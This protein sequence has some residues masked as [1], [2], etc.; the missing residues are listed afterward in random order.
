MF[1]FGFYLY[2]RGLMSVDLNPLTEN[3]V[4]ILIELFRNVFIYLL[5]F[6]RIPNP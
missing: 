4:C 5:I 3:P 1:I 6:L 2:M